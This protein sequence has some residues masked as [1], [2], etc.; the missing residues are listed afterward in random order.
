VRCSTWSLALPA[1]LGSL[2]SRAFLWSPPLPAFG[3]DPAAMISVK[4]LML[5][6]SLQLPL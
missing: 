1:S 2:A 4:K 5:D 6:V 3:D